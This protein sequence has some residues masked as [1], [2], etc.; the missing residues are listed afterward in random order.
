MKRIL[1]YTVFLLVLLLMTVFA[2]AYDDTGGHWAKESIEEWS[3]NGLINGKGNNLFDPDGNMTRAEAAAIFARLLKLEE[4][5]DIS[6]FSDVKESDWY[7]DVISKCVCAGILNG[8]NGKMNPNQYVSREMFC[9][10]TA[11][12]LGIIPEKKLNKSFVDSSSISDW[13]KGSMNALVNRGYIRGVTE[14]TVVPKASITRASVVTLIDRIVANY[15]SNELKGN[16]DAVSLVFS[17]VTVEKGFSGTVTVVS[18]GVE[19]SLKGAKNIDLVIMADNVKVKDIPSGTF[20]TVSQKAD[21]TVLNNKKAE[22]N[23]VFYVNNKEVIYMSTQEN[24]FK[25][26]YKKPELDVVEFDDEDVINTSTDNDDD[27]LEWDELL[28]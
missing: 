9:T 6:Q 21:G 4:K 5:A 10:M 14:N 28:Y 24:T 16:A 20:V 27:Q 26:E 25:E 19:L 8:D 7:Y 22:N 13:S 15:N 12:A 18:D 2:H 1:R 17:N 23:S 11:R 3:G